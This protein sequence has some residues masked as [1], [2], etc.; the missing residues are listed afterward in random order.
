MPI[1]SVD[2]SSQL[3]KKLKVNYRNSKPFWFIPR[4]MVALFKTSG[5]N[6]AIIVSLTMTESS[7]KIALPVILNFLLQS[8]EKNDSVGTSY[9]WASILGGLGIVQTVTHHVLFFYSMRAGWNWKNG[10]TALIH[11][12][13]FYL[14]G[15]KLQGAKTSTGMM[16]N[17]ISNDVAR[18]EEFSVV[19]VD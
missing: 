5:W 15:G 1:A 19:S 10:C 17:L 13:L 11:D 18:F 3:L 2:S 6:C 8:L 7:I 12:R 9:M 4:L 14:D 16:V